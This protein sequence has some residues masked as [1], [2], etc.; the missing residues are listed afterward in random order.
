MPSV[1]ETADWNSQGFKSGSQTDIQNAL[2]WFP[3]QACAMQFA[4]IDV[5]MIVCWLHFLKKRLNAD[6][7]MRQTSQSA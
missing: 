4:L 1:V 2:D 5:V 7:S 3:S 6:A